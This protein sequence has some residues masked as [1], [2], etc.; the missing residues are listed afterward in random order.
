MSIAYVDPGNIEG[1]LQAGVASGYGLLWVVAWATGLGFLVQMQSAKLGVATSRDLAQHC[2]AAYPRPA[3]LALWVAAQMA[4]VGA[5]VQECVGSAIALRLLSGGR[6]PLPA[7]VAVG[8]LASALL[9]TVERWGARPMEAALG[10]LVAVMV[11]AF[12]AM[13]ARADISARGVAE[14]FAVPR[15]ESRASV[16]QAVALVGSILMPHNTFLHSA[17]VQSRALEDR[18]EA[19]RDALRYYRIESG[20]S[21]A[22]SVGINAC[23]V[24]VFAAGFHGGGGG[25]GGRGAAAA[26]WVGGGGGMAGAGAGAT[27]SGP[28]TTMM[29]MMPDGASLSSASASASATAAVMAAVAAEDGGGGS[30]ASGGS[31]GPI[32]RPIGLENA[33][34]YLQRAYGPGA[35][36][37]WALGLLAAGQSSSCTGTYTSQ[38]LVA[39]IDAPA[40]LAPWARV[41]AAR[42]AALLPTL[43]VAALYSTRLD[44]MSQWMNLLQALVL[45][46]V[47]LPLLALNAS[48]AVVGR[49]FANPPA[50]TAALGAASA[51]VVVANLAGV[52]AF[53]A[54]AMGAMPARTPRGAALRGAIGLFGVGYGAL[55]LY[56]A[57]L[58]PAV[59]RH[60]HARRRGALRDALAGGRAWL[61][62]GA[63]A[64]KGGEDVAGV[65]GAGEAGEEAATRAPL[66][67]LGGSRAA[68]SAEGAE[69]EEEEEEEVVA[70]APALAGALG[71]RAQAFML[72]AEAAAAD[73]QESHGSPRRSGPVPPPRPRV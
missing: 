23:V 31:G 55:L 58:T 12:G 16:A 48:P 71:G 14:G 47:L 65:A 36:V 35:A 3:R 53:L 66:L 37:V 72:S 19:R 62:A 59:A 17:L 39:M 30:G 38:F 20:L 67:L 46:C 7:G 57:A 32:E 45:P 64:R 26:A 44:E 63:W 41:A 50:T 8:A 73:A 43:A 28:T 2:R 42:A 61:L 18:V 5:D 56:L 40:S 21:L 60:G 13:A 34:Y 15:L 52:A 29:T 49:A 51:A 27:A 9:L 11:V 25:G 6:L 68:V 22:V 54:E 69:E 70:L 33:G 4:V 24:S 10:A 1:D